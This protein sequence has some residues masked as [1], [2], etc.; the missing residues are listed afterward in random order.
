MS[1]ELKFKTVNMKTNF[2]L[3]LYGKFFY[4]KLE[5]SQLDVFCAKTDFKS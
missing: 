5:G 3:R 2:M 1:M 4:E